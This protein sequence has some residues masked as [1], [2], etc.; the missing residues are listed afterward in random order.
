MRQCACIRMIPRAR[1]CACA[2]VCARVCEH[3]LQVRALYALFFWFTCAASVFGGAWMGT[4]CNTSMGDAIL[5]SLRSL[6]LCVRAFHN[7]S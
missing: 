3:V 4:Y 2:H 6:L 5:Q 1:V 7:P